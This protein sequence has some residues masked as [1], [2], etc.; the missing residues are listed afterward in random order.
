MPK[1]K[2]III[3]LLAP[4][5]MAFMSGT[6]NASKEDVKKIDAVAQEIQTLQQH[7]NAA[8]E[9]VRM[10]YKK[11]TPL[12]IPIRPAKLDNAKPL[13]NTQKAKPIRKK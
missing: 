6:A 9:K 13:S 12:Q 7:L 4:L 1:K 8:N 10:L 2:K 5:L 3:C 11:Q